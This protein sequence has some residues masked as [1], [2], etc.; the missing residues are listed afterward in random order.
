MWF[1][2]IRTLLMDA[3]WLGDIPRPPNDHVHEAVAS[4]L[5]RMRDTTT[6]DAVELIER[7]QSAEVFL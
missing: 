1:R 7:A 5:V 4:K 3:I 6:K 2:P